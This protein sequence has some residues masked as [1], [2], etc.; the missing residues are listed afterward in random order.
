MGACQ[1]KVKYF[2]LYLPWDQGLVLCLTRRRRGEAK[3]V[4]HHGFYIRW[5]LISLC[6]HLESI[7]H[8]DLLKAFGYIE[9]VGKSD[10]FSEKT[11]FTSYVRG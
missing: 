5:L 4:K 1:H 10:F 8:F 2:V 7:R 6:A 9:R 11:Y 3:L